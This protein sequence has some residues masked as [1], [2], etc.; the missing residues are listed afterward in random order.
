MRFSMLSLLAL[1]G[2]TSI[3]SIDGRE[4][5]PSFAQSCD[6]RVYQTYQS[7]IARGPI[8]E[9]CVINGSAS[10]SFDKSVSGTINRH[11]LKACACGATEVYIQSRTGGDFF[12]DT[13]VNMVAFRRINKKPD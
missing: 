12:S 5:D 11:K 9:L 13:T 1:S 7:A 8:E 4:I 3:T 10:M 6:V 2:C